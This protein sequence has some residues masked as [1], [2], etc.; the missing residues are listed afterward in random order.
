MAQKHGRYHYFLSGA[1]GFI[2]SFGA[3]VS[4]A[5]YYFNVKA[6]DEAIPSSAKIAAASLS[7]QSLSTLDTTIIKPIVVPSTST[8]TSTTTSTEPVAKSEN[9]ADSGASSNSKL[10]NKLENPIKADEDIKTTDLM[11]SAVTKLN[12]TRPSASNPIP[13][14]LD[15]FKKKVDDLS[16]GNHIDQSEQLLPGKM[17]QMEATAYCLNG[18]TASGVGSKYGIIAADPKHLP[19]GSVVRIYTKGYSGLYTVLDTGAMIKG[20]KID[21]Y[22]TSGHEAV[23]FGHRKIAL[24]VLRYGWNPQNSAMPF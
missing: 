24:E 19:I 14:E 16:R 23:Q 2:I 20:H 17:V 6:N 18:Q 1:A 9:K 13:A 11:A 7:V 10:E 8:T 15:T 21:V 12:I 22:L 4:P 3:I 5:A